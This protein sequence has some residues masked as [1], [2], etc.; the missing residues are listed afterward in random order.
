MK[1]IIRKIL[2]KA[3]EEKDLELAEKVKRLEAKYI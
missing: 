2:N 1:D 3:I